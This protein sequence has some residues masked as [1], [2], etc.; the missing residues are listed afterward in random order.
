MP[1]IPVRNR[2][3]GEAVRVIAGKYGGRKG[4]KHK[5]KGETESQVY[6]ILQAVSQQQ[7]R[8]AQPSKVVRIS[9]SHVIKFEVAVT[10]AQK[11]LEQ[12][13]KLQEKMTDLAK[14]LVKLNIEPNEDMIVTFGQQWLIMW[15]KKQQTTTID[16]NR[17]ESPPTVPNV[18]DDEA[19]HDEDDHNEDGMPE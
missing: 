5:E 11:A 13:P 16:Y 3:K 12:K 2:D 10:Q 18:S 6:V 9:K 8:P 1:T 19:D 4:W 14:E 17:T 15:N 7:G